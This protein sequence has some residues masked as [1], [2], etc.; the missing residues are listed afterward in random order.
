LTSPPAPPAT[1]Q[2]RDPLLGMRLR[3]TDYA[4]HIVRT[5]KVAMDAA[6]ISIINNASGLLPLQEL[7]R[8]AGL[9]PA[10]TADVGRKLLEAGYLVRAEGSTPVESKDPLTPEMRALVRKLRP[11]LVRYAGEEAAFAL[12]LDARQCHDLPGL[13]I[14]MRRRF[15]DASAREDFTAAVKRELGDGSEA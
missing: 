2:Q 6:T 10:G 5:K 3:R 12:E 14:A 9:S 11:I 15:K 7:G 4:L 8:L 13:V 1:L